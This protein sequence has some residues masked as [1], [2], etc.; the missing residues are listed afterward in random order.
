MTNKEYRA[1][2]AAERKAQIKKSPSAAMRAGK[3]VWENM[4]G[5]RVRSKKRPAEDQFNYWT[6][7]V[8]RARVTGASYTPYH[9]GS[10]WER[11]ANAA[12]ADEAQSNFQ[13]GQR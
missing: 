12:M 6:P 10:E 8:P 11:L 1:Y 9:G 3:N 13:R 5:D 4:D 7:V 2:V